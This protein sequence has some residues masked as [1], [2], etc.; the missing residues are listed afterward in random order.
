MWVTKQNFYS[1]FIGKEWWPCSKDCTKAKYFLE[2]IFCFWY[3][4]LIGQCDS[5]EVHCVVF[6]HGFP[7]LCS[8]E[9]FGE[10]PSLP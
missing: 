10:G 3:A 1:F 4:F 7:V 5:Y 6:N 8:R 9:S 2:Y